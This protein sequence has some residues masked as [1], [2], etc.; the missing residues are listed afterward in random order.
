[1][2]KTRLS[3][4]SGPLTP[5]QISDGMNAARKNAGRL[6]Q[7]AR[8]LLENSRL[9]SATASA[10]LSIEES[11]KTNV[12]RSL[13]I[14]N[15][16]QEIKALWKEYRSHTKKNVLALLPELVRQGAHSL[17]D[18]AHF[19]SGRRASSPGGVDEAVGDL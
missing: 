7:D 12:L 14:A 13:A 2:A 3:Q 19:R 18:P 15:D 5:A 8:L 16:T 9:A 4:Y 6:A 11:G 1:M 17:K 10:I